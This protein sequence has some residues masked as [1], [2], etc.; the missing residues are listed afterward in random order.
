M[1]TELCSWSDGDLM[2][3]ASPSLCLG[4]ISSPAHPSVQ[5]HPLDR[6]HARV[7]CVPQKRRNTESIDPEKALTGTRDGKDLKGH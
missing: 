6:D 1:E 4:H 5:V 2:Y 7:F 3:P